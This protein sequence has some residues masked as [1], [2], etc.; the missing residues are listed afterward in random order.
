[1]TEATELLML[2]FVLILGRKSKKLK[3]SCGL[4]DFIAFYLI[5]MF[6]FRSFLRFNHMC[7]LLFSF[8]LVMLKIMH[9]FFELPLK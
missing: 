4:G 7:Y 6:K 2:S 9:V 5:C 3:P 8:F 1:M